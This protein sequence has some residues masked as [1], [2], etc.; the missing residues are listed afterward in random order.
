MDKYIGFD[1]DS[2]KTVACVIQKGERDRY[3]TLKTDIGQMKSFL[4]QQ[5]RPGEKLNLTFEISGQAGYMYDSLL[6]SVDSITVSNPS[7]MTWIYR[8]AKKNDRI[9]ARKQ[10][11][12]LSIGEIPKVHMPKKQIRQWRRTIQHRRKQVKHITQVK[13][14]TRALLKSV[15]ITKPGCSKSWWTKSNRNWMYRLCQESRDTVDLGW[16]LNLKHMLEHLNLLECQRNDI[17]KRL[18]D[19]L[20][21]R[22]G[23][24]LLR[25]IP[26]IGP[27]TAEAILA[28]TDDAVRFRRTRQYCA[29]FG[30]TP[31]LD[32][33]GSTRRLGHI[34][35]QGPSVVRW[36]IVESTWRAIRCSP[37]LKAFYERIMAGQKSRKKIALIATARKILTI[38][39]AMLTTGEFFNERL[40][41][42]Y[43]YLQDYRS[44]SSKAK[45]RQLIHN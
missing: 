31:R 13:N 39:R 12:L 21:K 6:N 22:P 17:T 9:D 36:L 45:H 42:Q 15:G 24:M 28:Y 26:G 40:V 41:S 2:K 11:L 1:V 34:S 7:K 10:A 38:I 4:Q 16:Q 32:E 43:C 8:T 25:S 30:L 20:L 19:Y 23:W 29:Y 3:T 27:R 44:I 33:S 37:S 5:R 14:S 18:D 35:K